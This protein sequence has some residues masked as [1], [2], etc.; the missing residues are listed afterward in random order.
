MN[1]YFFAA[2]VVMAIVIIAWA[3]GYGNDAVSVVASATGMTIEHDKLGWMDDE[4]LTGA[5]TA[6]IA[7][8]SGQGYSDN[9]NVIRS[10][11]AG[12]RSA[13]TRRDFEL[14]RQDRRRA[15]AAYPDVKEDELYVG[16]W[17]QIDFSARIP[18]SFCNSGNSNG[19]QGADGKWYLDGGC[20]VSVVRAEFS[21][22][23]DAATT[24]KVLAE[25]KNGQRQKR[26]SHIQRW[27]YST[28]SSGTGGSMSVNCYPDPLPSNEEADD[29]HVAGQCVAILDAKTKYVFPFVATDWLDPPYSQEALAKFAESK[30][31]KPLAYTASP[32][33]PWKIKDGLLARGQIGK[34]G[35]LYE[36]MFNW[37]TDDYDNT[38]IGPADPASWIL[39]RPFG[40]A[41]LPAPDNGERHS[42]PGKPWYLIATYY[43]F[44]PQVSGGWDENECKAQMPKLQTGFSW[45]MQGQDPEE[46]NRGNLKEA[47]C[48]QIA[49]TTGAL[50]LKDK[51]LPVQPQITRESETPC[52]QGMTLMPGQSCV[53]GLH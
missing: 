20:Y 26:L 14:L 27:G 1:A 43:G 22:R 3:T 42:T 13:I 2:V 32:P 39:E 25:L 47:R 33:K 46:L 6:R 31:A 36:S 8:I 18:D 35:R 28:W 5:D 34:P 4:P 15:R 11:H 12:G 9:L 40:I 49:P 19:T 44:A 16:T 37:N 7:Q 30:G 10:M 50:I 24:K 48:T 53:A 45:G 23:A 38:D 51:T 29:T 52:T 21:K 17:L 41:Y